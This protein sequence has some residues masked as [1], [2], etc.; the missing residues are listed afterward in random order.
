MKIESIFYV[1]GVLFAT[2]AIV[3]FTWDYIITLATISKI[4]VMIALFVMFFFI[5]RELERMKK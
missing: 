4:I 5:G 1:L 3:Y 2:I